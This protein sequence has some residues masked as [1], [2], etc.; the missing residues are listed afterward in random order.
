MCN[1]IPNLPIEM[2]M[3]GII[4]KKR[5]KMFPVGLIANSNP[6]TK[7]ETQ[8]VDIYFPKLI[9]NYW[10]SRFAHARCNKIGAALA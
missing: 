2:T 5:E 10:D 1:A 7:L 4:K 9:K 6:R 3:V 8:Q